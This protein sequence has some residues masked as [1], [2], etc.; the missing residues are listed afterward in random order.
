MTS[1]AARPYKI[2]VADPDED[3]FTRLI[4]VLAARMEITLTRGSVKYLIERHYKLPKRALRFCHPRDLLTQVQNRA[5]FLGIEKV[6]GPPEWDQAV[7]GY[8]GAGG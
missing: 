7:A 1:V 2:Y 5:D 8:F 3:E 6:C 4:E